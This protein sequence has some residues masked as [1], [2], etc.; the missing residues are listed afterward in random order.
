KAAH[1]R[2]GAVHIVRVG[3]IALHS[4]LVCVAE[5]LESRIQYP[6]HVAHF[7]VVPSL[8]VGRHV[9]SGK[10]REDESKTRNDLKSSL[11]LFLLI[12]PSK[13][14]THVPILY[15]AI[16]M[17]KVVCHQAAAMSAQHCGKIL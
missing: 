16:L 9:Q 12:C 11:H 13:Y 7:A 14:G 2:V 5:I 17:P 4:I 15:E 3:R 6:D 8:G 1:A 10:H